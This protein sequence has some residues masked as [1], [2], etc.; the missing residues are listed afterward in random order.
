ML[1][2]QIIFNYYAFL[3]NLF[4]HLIHLLHVES[5]S[6]QGSTIAID[7]YTLKAYSQTINIK[8]IYKYNG[9]ITIVIENVN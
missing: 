4:K 1:N 9:K 2:G 8:Y 5:L 3:V 6:E 7:S